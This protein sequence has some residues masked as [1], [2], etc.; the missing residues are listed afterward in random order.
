MYYVKVAK[1]Y[2]CYV[3][4]D[5]PLDLCLTIICEKTGLDID[6]VIFQSTSTCN[7]LTKLDFE[8]DIS[9]TPNQLGDIACACG[10]AF[11]DHYDWNLNMKIVMRANTM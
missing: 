10:T 1:R 3:R 5:I 4:K 11:V 2:L 6:S 9:K 8:I 7:F